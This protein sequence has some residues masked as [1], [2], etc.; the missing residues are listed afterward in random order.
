MNHSHIYIYWLVVSTPLNILVNWVWD[1]I[2]NIWENTSHA[3]VTTNQYNSLFPNQPGTSLSIN[4]AA[5][6]V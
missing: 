6:S 1:E 2:P 4:E 5:P 3:P